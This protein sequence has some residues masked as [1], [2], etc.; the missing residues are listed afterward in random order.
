MKTFLKLLL[1]SGSLLLTVNATA[2][3]HSPGSA[4][5]APDQNFYVFLCFGQSNME[6][7]PGIEDQDKTFADSRF[8]MLAA[9]DFPTMD[10]KQDNWYTAVPP[11][12]RPGT[13][14]CPA[15]FFGRTLVTALPQN[16][17]VGVVNVAVA[18]AKIEIFDQAAYQAYLSSLPPSDAYKKNIAAG[19]G[20]SPY[21]R[22]V[23]LGKLAQKTGVI[24]GILLHQGESN[25]N[26]KEWPNKVKKIYESLLEDLDLRA[27]DVPLLAGEV[28]GDD[29][30]GQ[31]A[32]MNKI[33]AD[34]PKTIPTAH[35]I[36]SAGCIARA[37]HLHFSPEGY[38]EFGQRYAEAMLP[39]L[40]YKKVDSSP[41]NINATASPATPLS[42]AAPASGIQS[43]PQ[44]ATAG[45]ATATTTAGRR[46][47]RGPAGPQ[48]KVTADHRDW[49]YLPGETVKYTVMAP[50]GTKITYTIGPDMM[51]AES[52]SAVIPE[53]GSLELDG[54]TMKDP[55]FLRCVVTAAGGGRGLATAAFSPEKI[56]PTQTEPADFDAFWTKAKAELA[57][58]PMDAKL[59]PM[60]S[61]TTDK[62]EAFEISL[63]NIG[64]PPATTSRFYGIL[65]IPRGDGPFPAMMSPPGAGVR[66]PD[67]D[68]WGWC[69]RGFIVLYVGI[70]EVPMRPLPDAGATTSVPGNYPNV[71]LDDP[72]HYYF[73]RVIMGCLRADDYLVT[74]PK[75]DHKNLIAYGG[76]QGGYL[77]LTTTA[78]D[79]RVTCCEVSY[80]AYGD[81]VA[82]LYGRPAGWPALKF[83]DPKADAA[84]I[85]TTAYFDSVN[86]ARR[87][88]VPGHYAWGY[89]DETCPP[90]SVFSMYNVLT[91]PKV[92][93]IYKELGHARNQQVTDDEHDWLMRQVGK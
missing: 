83:N 41:I 37:D 91:A 70:H 20:G 14:L 88:K 53:S 3:D 35:V 36:S 38:R 43:Q 16:I 33:I 90:D 85:A 9:V 60:P 29:Q 1:A 57:D 55:G 6:G 92:L 72:N 5:A 44:P 21:Q 51:P 25:T 7:Y 66:G 56:K 27:E 42:A 34:L 23:E 8:Q 17:R 31:C 45:S 13:G 67:V 76:S 46:G 32:S 84:K 59:T 52:K 81:E 49:N 61:E 87:I 69:D 65:Y 62:H 40:G 39:L 82:Y 74:L 28:V 30:K 68:L 93:Q 71:G 47:A 4:S 75:W 79:P 12:C 78:L 73:R 22:L 19:Y 11:L 24:K 63:Q 89:N 86:F 77:S 26:D 15:D 10:R 18:G 80:P 2:Q 54:G 64:T 58:L 48:V 50:A